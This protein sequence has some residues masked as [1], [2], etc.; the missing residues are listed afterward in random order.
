MVRALLLHLG[1]KSFDLVLV[2]GGLLRNELLVL[3]NV[4]LLLGLFLSHMHKS[5][6]NSIQIHFQFLILSFHDH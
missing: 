4:D 6:I 3:N 1:N 2:D 5:L